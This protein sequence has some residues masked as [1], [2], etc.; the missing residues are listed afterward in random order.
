MNPKSTQSDE[1]YHQDTDLQI[2]GILFKWLK[3]RSFLDIGAEKGSFAKALFSMGFE[4]G[5]LFEPLP[6]HLKHLS[7]IFADSAA[8]I[9]PC[10]VDRE[11]RTASFNIACDDT[12]EELNYFHSLN[13]I[14]N[15]DF[16]K[17]SK[18]LDVLCRSLESLLASGEIFEDIGVLK[19]DTE[20]ND[21]R[22]LQGIG[23]LRPELVVCEFVPPA[24]YPDW[25]LSFAANLIPEAEKLG[26]THVVAIQR[27]HG[28]NIES[29]RVDPNE[30]TNNDWGNLIFIRHDLF[31]AA[32]TALR[33]WIRKN[34]DR[35]HGT[36][37]I[38]VVHDATYGAA[39]K[40]WFGAQLEGFSRDPERSFVLDVGAHEGD[41]S[42]ACLD[43]S[44][45]SGAILFE[46]H[47]DNARRLRETFQKF[48]V[49]VEEMA[50]GACSATGVFLFGDDSATGSLLEPTGLAKDSVGRSKVPITTLDDYAAANGLMDRVAVLKIDTQGTDLNVLK[51]AELLLRESQPIIVVEMIFAPLYENQN[52]PSDLIL[53]LTRQGY[54]LTGFFDEHFS[55]EGWLAWCDACFLPVGRLSEYKAPFTIRAS[56]PKETIPSDNTY[57]NTTARIVADSAN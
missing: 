11:D 22:V 36:E 16:F 12:G 32:S 53:W 4:R 26:Y 19:I 30:F 33:A 38:S 46:P 34:D 35:F 41:F 48:P 52:E 44:L 10:A 13:K 18:S 5:I 31:D 39:F 42:R 15:H 9:M 55:R 37:T 28:S 6:S 40:K 3:T 56:C 57:N 20:G 47:P 17:H 7:D 29:V 2:I 24:V 8:K 50:V 43:T 27:T 25:H 51:G 14:A 1:L 49:T 21:L 23:G 54:T 45:I